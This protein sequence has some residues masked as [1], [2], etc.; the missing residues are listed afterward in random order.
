MCPTDK[1]GEV[2]MKFL[3]LIYILI[4]S[5]CFSNQDNSVKVDTQNKTS[6]LSEEFINPCYNY[7]GRAFAKYYKFTFSEGKIT[8]YTSP[9][10]NK[11]KTDYRTFSSMKDFLK[12]A[13][14]EGNSV[15]SPDE[16]DPFEECRLVQDTGMTDDDMFIKIVGTRFSDCNCDAVDHC[17][18]K[19]RKML[20]LVPKCLKS[21]TG[22]TIKDEML[23]NPKYTDL[24]D[25]FLDKCFKKTKKNIKTKKPSGR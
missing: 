17:E 25:F 11:G 6:T 7:R 24:S 9:N 18:S 20:S 2:Q 10:D 4:S 12:T 13:K 14:N 22:C 3:S 16:Q 5:V 1:A 21:D 19:R 15:S 23:F 8:K